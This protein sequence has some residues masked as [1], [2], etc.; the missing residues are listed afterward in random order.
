MSRAAHFTFTSPRS[1]RN[2]SRT[3]NAV[4]TPR[5]LSFGA[6]RALGPPTI[7][8][9]ALLGGVNG[10]MYCWHLKERP[11]WEAARRGGTNAEIGL[12][13]FKLFKLTLNL[14]RSYTPHQ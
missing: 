11:P 13:F 12:H 14:M 10:S 7:I 4:H 3:A 8:P 6:E 2:E 1:P 9:P 5:G